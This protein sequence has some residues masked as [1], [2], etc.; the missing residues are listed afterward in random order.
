[1]TPVINMT[2]TGNNIETLRIKNGYSIRELQQAMG[3]VSIQAIYKWESGQ[4]IP[5]IDNLVLLSELFHVPVD[6]IVKRDIK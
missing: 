6:Q 5:S 3:T 1:M 2:S 4:A